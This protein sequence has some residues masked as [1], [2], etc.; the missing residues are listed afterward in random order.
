MGLLTAPRAFA[1]ARPASGCSGGG[2]FGHRVRQDESSV[3]TD[4]ATESSRR[5]LGL[6]TAAKRRTVQREA[7]C[8]GTGGVMEVYRWA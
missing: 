6:R 2:L 7:V 5:V 1:G 8:P 4:V 3:C